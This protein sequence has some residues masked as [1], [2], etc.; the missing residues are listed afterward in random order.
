MSDGH[1]YDGNNETS[2]TDSIII[3]DVVGVVA[4]TTM[5]MPF[6]YGTLNKP[7]STNVNENIF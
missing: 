6:W 7:S 2:A 4:V 1:F 3:I 5:T